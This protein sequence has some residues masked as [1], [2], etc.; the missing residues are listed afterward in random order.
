[1]TIDIQHM[2][3]DIEAREDLF[4][5]SQAWATGIIIGVKRW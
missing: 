4:L 5:T 2:T 1:M 3:I